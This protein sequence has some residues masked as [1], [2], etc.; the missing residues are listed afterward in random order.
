MEYTNTNRGNW[1]PIKDLLK[2]KCSPQARFGAQTSS[3]EPS[4]TNEADSNPWG[5]FQQLTG[6]GKEEFE[7]RARG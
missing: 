6:Q 1:K 4:L 7:T 3:N 2:D 5:R